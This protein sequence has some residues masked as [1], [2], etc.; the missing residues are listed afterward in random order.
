M[1]YQRN[2]I[3][4]KEANLKKIVVEYRPLATGWSILKATQLFYDEGLRGSEAQVTG[5]EAADT[6]SEAVETPQ[7][8]YSQQTL[9]Q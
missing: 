2:E 5:N 9:D 1:H 4:D 8:P 3:V 6:V 7:S